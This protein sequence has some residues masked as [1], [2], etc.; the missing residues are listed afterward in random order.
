MKNPIGAVVASMGFLMSISKF[1][2]VVSFFMI[3][4]GTILS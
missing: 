2:E 4:A 1:Y 3:L